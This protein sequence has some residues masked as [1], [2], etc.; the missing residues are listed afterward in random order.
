VKN[1]GDQIQDLSRQARKAQKEASDKLAQAGADIQENKLPQR[2]LSGNAMIQNG[3]YESQKQ[4]EDYIR[5]SLES[6][7]RQLESARSSVGQG[8]GEKL[9]E[10]ANRARQLSEGLESMQQRL[11]QS[12][13]G[14]RQQG[15]Q[16]QP[17]QQGQQGRGGQQG[18]QTQ[19]GQQ[20]PQ[21]QRGQQQGQGQ[22]QAGQSPAAQGRSG[23]LSQNNQSARGSIEQNLQNG[24][25]GPDAMVRDLS[26]NSSGAPVGVGTQRNEQE[27]QL[28]RELQQRLADAQEMRPLLDR[29]STQ[30][31]NLEKVIESLRK[32]GDYMNADPEQVAR[33][34][35]AID[36]MRKV[37]FDLARDLDRL[38]QNDKYFSAE[39]NEAP[40]SYRKLV[41]EYYK[42]IAKSK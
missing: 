39:D 12:Q 33:L 40:G 32:A 26:G 8:K 3:F 6:L 11:S 34:K 7:N 28:S 21:G 41:E 4:R 25:P 22:N 2:I 37:E 17:G 16:A 36:Y 27:R 13:Q 10:A 19:Q 38:N 31:Q 42:S 29:N 23:N 18:Q 20:G 35:S 14:Q 24:R 1:L 5:G 9:E 15:Q 30:M